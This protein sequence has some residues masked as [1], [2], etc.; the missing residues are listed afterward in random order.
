MPDLEKDRE[1]KLIRIILTGS[2][3]C[4]IIMVAFI[5]FTR[6]R[7]F[8]AFSGLSLSLMLSW[9]FTGYFYRRK[10]N[11][12]WF[13]SL[14]FVNFFILVPELSLRIANF[15]YEFGIQFGYPRPKEFVNLVPDQ[16]LFW[17]MPSSLEGVNSL[18][19]QEREIITPKPNNVYR[20]LYLGDSCTQ[21]GYP[22]FVES[23]LN[24]K[25]INDLKHIECVSLGMSGYSS[26]QGRVLSESYHSEM[27]PDLIVVYYG[28]NDHW[29]AYEAIDSEKIVR[30]APSNQITN[31][32]FQ[33][34]RIFQGIRKLLD[35]ITKSN[36]P[37]NKVRV[38]VDQY[39]QNLLKISEVFKER[40]VQIIF[41]TAPTSHYRLGVPDYLVEEKF[42][43][44]KEFAVLM[45]KKYNQVVRD[46]AKETESFLLDL[47][48]D[49]NMRE[50]LDDIF[51]R[52]GIH[53]TSFGINE[54]A[55]HIANFVKAN[56]LSSEYNL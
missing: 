51:M 19:F 5:T 32:L 50:N 40:G 3:L 43:P 6:P 9:Y 29:L 12:E 35:L 55:I 2:L 52:D 47:E 27:D 42:T 14:A 15:H 39:R 16:K 25:Q 13:L 30:E 28:W 34:L 24:E 18:G 8:L 1:L 49:F 26:F 38:P 56:V 48:S 33:H 22:N 46:V 41:I 53:F 17:K 37:L 21:Q 23:I 20:I 45:H 11:I 31:Y 4:S 44:D 10:M 54:V 7:W 36:E